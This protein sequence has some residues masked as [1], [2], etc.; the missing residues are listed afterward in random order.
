MYEERHCLDVG[1][2]KDSEEV[3]TGQDIKKRRNDSHN[4]DLGPDKLYPLLTEGF[5]AEV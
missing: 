4:R 3:L 5:I 2:V 1:I